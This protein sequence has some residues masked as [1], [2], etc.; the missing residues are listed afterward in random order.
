MF[1]V[2]SL[3]T[4]VK[5]EAGVAMPILHPRTGAPMLRADGTPVTITLLGPNCATSKAISRQLQQRRTDFAAR[6]VKYADDDFARERFDL[7]VAV[8]RGWTF[9]LI[10]AK[11]FP[12]SVENARVFW[13][14]KRWDWLQ[15]QAFAFTREDGNFLPNS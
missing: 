13:A 15:N 11:P 2:A 8:T 4:S 6:G 10:D 12:F 5:S 7:L 3:D 1:D 9:D 14:D